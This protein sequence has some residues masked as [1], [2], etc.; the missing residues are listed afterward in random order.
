MNGEHPVVALVALV[1]VASLVAPVVA[2]VVAAQTTGSGQVLGWPGLSVTTSTPEL[3]AGGDQ[4]LALEILNDPDLRKTGPERY[5]NRVTT[6]RAVTITI[7]DG[8]LP[9]D[10]R[11]ETVAVG[12]V[13]PGKTSVPAVTVTVPESV[14]PGRYEIP[15]AVTYSYTRLVSY[16][17]DDVSYANGRRTIT[18]EVTV[19]VDARPRFA[20]TGTRST[21]QVGD[22]GTVTVTLENVGAEPAGDARITLVSS[23]ANARITGADGLG[24]NGPGGDR[25]SGVGESAIGSRTAVYVGEWRPGEERSATYT[26]AVDEDIDAESLAFRAA[27]EY[28]DTDGV[29]RTS[30][31]LALGVRPVPEQSFALDDV[32]ADLRVG[33]TGTISGTLV[34]TGETPVRNAVV[35]LSTESS[36]LVPRPTRIALSDLEPGGEASF[37]FDVHVSDAAA[38]TTHQADLTVEYRNQRGQLRRSDP[39][40]RSVAVAPERDR[41]ALTPVNATFE[42]DSDNPLR[43]RITNRESVTFREVRVG[44]N[45]TAP[46]TSESSTAYVEALDPGESALVVFEVTVS[47]DAVATTTAVDVTVTAREPDGDRIRDGPYVIPVT[48]TE[49]SGPGDTVLLG[50]GVVAILVVLGGGWWWLRR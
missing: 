24:G 35:V 25:P 42:V 46:F 10:V 23:S 36:E 4:S 41:F 20:V 29:T 17:G 22:T 12:E 40:E 15:V 50:V 44:I 13:P 5:E 38:A 9:F 27:V 34:N 3:T 39:L 26:V 6:A 43:V 28:E 37:S 48:V 18:D 21:L 16:D 32:R 2:P 30:R 33:R 31:P 11:S 49:A 47:E 7:D 19:R 1:V 45:A 14:P 8:D